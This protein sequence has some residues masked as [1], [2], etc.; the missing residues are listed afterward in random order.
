MY[1]RTTSCKMQ[2]KAMLLKSHVKLAKFSKVINKE[3]WHSA[4]DAENE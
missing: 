3:V 4:E 1:R 2:M